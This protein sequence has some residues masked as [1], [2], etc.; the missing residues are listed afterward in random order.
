MNIS[1]PYNFSNKFDTDSDTDSDTK[2]GYNP[3]IS[4]ISVFYAIVS[5]F[6]TI[7]CLFKSWKLVIDQFFSV[8][9]A[10]KTQ[11]QIK[12]RYVNICVNS[13]CIGSIY[14]LT[15][16]LSS[17]FSIVIRVNSSGH[18]GIH[19]R[20]QGIGV[21]MSKQNKVVLKDDDIL[22]VHLATVF[23]T[24]DK[25]QLIYLGKDDVI[26]HNIRENIT[27]QFYKVNGILYISEIPEKAR[28]DMRKLITKRSIIRNDGRFMLR[29]P[30]TV[31][32]DTGMKLD[33]LS[34]HKT[35]FLTF[36]EKSELGYINAS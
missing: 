31:R 20:L 22:L 16:C 35:G 7:F 8:F 19:I 36:K 27:F 1:H 4:Y 23:I 33:L 10:L 34:N 32:A 29:V 21:F 9:H 11:Y 12:L 3:L 18:F 26:F 25:E 2:Q 17:L 28:L 24:G 30:K 14:S 5:D 13:I 15:I 6:C